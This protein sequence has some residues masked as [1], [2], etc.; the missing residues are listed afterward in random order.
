MCFMKFFKKLVA[1]LVAILCLGVSSAYADDLENS[2]FELGDFTGWIVLDDGGDYGFSCGEDDDVI[3]S[4]GFWEIVSDDSA[5]E[6]TNFAY[7]T[8]EGPSWGALGRVLVNS[9]SAQNDLSLRL[10]YSNAAEEWAMDSDFPLVLGEAPGDCEEVVCNFQNQWLRVDILHEGASLN[11]INS[12]DIAHVAFD[13]RVE[14]APYYSGES[15]ITVT[16]SN[17]NLPSGTF[18]LRIITVNNLYFFPVGIDNLVFEEL[19][20][21]DSLFA[22]DANFNQKVAS[23]RRDFA[24]DIQALLSPSLSRYES[25][26]FFDV[27]KGNIS[28]VNADLAAAYKASVTAGKAMTEAEIVAQASSLA[29]RYNTIDRL[30]TNPESV[31]ATDLVNIGLTGLDNSARKF[32]LMRELRALPKDQIDTYAELE[33]AIKTL[34][35]PATK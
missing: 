4:C 32:T 10:S 16:I 30:I 35:A 8:M 7:W 3:A 29:L 23:C 24:S 12:D 18:T 34:T 14:D 11:T 21:V 25:C 28:R 26:M 17:E 15:F 22:Q 27:T 20:T 9:P 13:A 5:P 1:L 31:Y 33:A 19:T 6:G 2:G